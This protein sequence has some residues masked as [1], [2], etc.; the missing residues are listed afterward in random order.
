MVERILTL[1]NLHKIN[2]KTSSQKSKTN[3]LKTFYCKQFTTGC[4]CSATKLPFNNS[5]FDAIWIYPANNI[6]C[7]CCKTAQDSSNLEKILKLEMNWKVSSRSEAFN[8][9]NVR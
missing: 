3:Q 9:G 4:Y 6:S 8:M 5:S 1:N 7:N 2:L